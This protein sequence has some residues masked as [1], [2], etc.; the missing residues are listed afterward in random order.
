MTPAQDPVLTSE[1]RFARTGLLAVL[2]AGWGSIVFK[3]V[4]DAIL[5]APFFVLTTLAT[6]ALAQEVRTQARRRGRDGEAS[7]EGTDTAILVVLVGL[8]LASSAPLAFRAFSP[9][10][11]SAGLAFA[12]LYAVLAGLFSWNRRAELNRR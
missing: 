2:A 12:A 7:W 5:S 9:P 10:E 1:G 6:A 4:N 8:A 11:Q 3:N